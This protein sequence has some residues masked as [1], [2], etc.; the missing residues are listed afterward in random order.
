[1]YKPIEKPQSYVR[2]MKANWDVGRHL[3]IVEI[4][5]Q[6][7]G[8]FVGVAAVGRAAGRLRF[9]DGDRRL[10]RGGGSRRRLRDRLGRPRGLGRT[11]EALEHLHRTA[12][13]DRARP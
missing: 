9:G 13:E 2:T 10:S 4:V 11:E 5:P 6:I 7:Q 3:V 12:T 1:M 8:V